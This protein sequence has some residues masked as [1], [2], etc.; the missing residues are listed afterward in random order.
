MHFNSMYKALNVSRRYSVVA[1]RV[2][3]LAIYPLH[4]S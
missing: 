1:C 4:L 3:I 2:Y